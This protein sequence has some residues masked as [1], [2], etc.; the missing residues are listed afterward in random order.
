MSTKC[1]EG[2]GYG[3]ILPLEFTKDVFARITC[4]H[5]QVLRQARVDVVSDSTQQRFLRPI[6]CRDF[7]RF[8]EHRHDHTGA[9][10]DA[11][12]EW[13]GYVHCGCGS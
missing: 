2:P 13:F 9:G 6:L 3:G 8:A 5:D 4:I 1:P 11:G 10:L 7:K 12:V